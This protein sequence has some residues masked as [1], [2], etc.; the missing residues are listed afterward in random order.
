MRDAAASA[1]QLLTLLIGIVIGFALAST[2]SSV[3]A[4]TSTPVSSPTP[5]ENVPKPTPVFPSIGAPTIGSNLI[6][7]HQL[8]ADR[9][10]VNGYDLLKIDEGIL[11]YLGNQP[12][13]NQAA[14]SSVIT[15]SRASDLHTIAHTSPPTS[16]PPVTPQK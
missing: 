9:A 3:T 15:N 14:I 7:V 4:Q 13:A 6:L 2:R 5:D 8:E 10:I 12:L 11:N 16:Q 1:L